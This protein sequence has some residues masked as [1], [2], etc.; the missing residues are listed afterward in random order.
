MEQDYRLQASRGGKQNQAV[1][2][3]LECISFEKAEYMQE[4]VADWGRRFMPALGLNIVEISG[5]ADVIESADLD[6][7]DVICTTPEKFGRIC[8]L[9]PVCMLSLS[10]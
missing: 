5:D 4:R 6:A 1:N 3:R 10:P 8:I 9:T 2:A 7:A